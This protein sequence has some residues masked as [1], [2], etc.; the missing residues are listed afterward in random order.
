MEFREK[1]FDNM[2]GDLEYHPKRALLYLALGMA[3]L[4]VWAFAPDGHK[5]DVVSNGVRGGWPGPFA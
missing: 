3:A 1:I 2:V 4:A 5:V